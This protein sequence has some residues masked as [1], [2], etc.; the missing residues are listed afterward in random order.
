MVNKMYNQWNKFTCA[1]QSL[2]DMALAKR[3][4]LLVRVQ[5]LG[6]LGNVLIEYDK[7]EETS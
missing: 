3:L 5:K 6:M 4:R 7:E 2:L 1:D